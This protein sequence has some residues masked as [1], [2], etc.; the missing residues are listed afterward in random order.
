MSD[1]TK[2]AVMPAL[3]LPFVVLSRVLTGCATKPEEPAA[4][5]DLEA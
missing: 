5:A 2:L 3:L 1:S 4:P